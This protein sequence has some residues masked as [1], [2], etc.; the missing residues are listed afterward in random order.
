MLKNKWG[1]IIFFGSSRALK[2]DVGISGYSLAK[3]ASLAY[4]KSLSKEYGSYGVTSNYIR[5]G[6]FKSP[7]LKNVKKKTLKKLLEETD[8][9]SLG[10]F[11]SL[12]NAL[13]F[14]IKSK[15]VT[16]SIIPV[17]GGFN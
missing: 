9:K 3:F 16:G 17:D 13:D 12:K 2:T 4:C 5:L 1:R 11:D 6:L 14:I 8:T 10:D 15:Y 7:L